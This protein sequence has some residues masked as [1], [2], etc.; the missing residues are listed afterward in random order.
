MKCSTSVLPGLQ[1]ATFLIYADTRYVDAVIVSKAKVDLIFA[2]HVH[3]YERTFGVANN[4]TTA[5]APIY[6]NIG[7]A[8]NR[9]G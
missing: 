2:G 9:E 6:I 7:D 4:K 5:G 8:G 1:P 3:S